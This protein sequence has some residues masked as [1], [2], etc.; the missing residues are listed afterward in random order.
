[1][2]THKNVAD[3]SPTER[4]IT[5]LMKTVYG[6]YTGKVVTGQA[7]Q[8]K[9]QPHS[10][11]IVLDPYGAVYAEK[12]DGLTFEKALEQAGFTFVAQNE[13]VGNV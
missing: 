9:W 11:E 4:T 13:E 12:H 5:E 6:F 10:L 8:V 7:L 2:S 3:L 1:M